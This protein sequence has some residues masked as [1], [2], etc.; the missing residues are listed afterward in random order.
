MRHLINKYLLISLSL[1][2]LH[3]QA[4]EQNFNSTQQQSVLIELFT[5]EGCSSC[6]PAE[7]YLNALKHHPQLWSVYIPVAF[8]VDYWDYLGWRDPY[9]YMAHAKRQYWY[10]KQR[11]LRTVY[12]PAFV[13]NGKA[14]RPGWINRELPKIASQ[15]GE[16]KVTVNGKQLTA[17][18]IPLRPLTEKLTL[19]IAVLAMN[20]VSHIQAGENTGRTA[21]HEFVV[22]G[23]KYLDSINGQWADNLPELHY[24]AAREH[25]I[26]VWISR[27]DDPTPLQAVGGQLS[28]FIE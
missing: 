1:M 26:A 17:S 28:Q 22:V 4:E 24:K 9:A 3:V 7:E 11:N 20:L 19:N 16:L 18:Y 23:Y 25:A 2:S 10:A 6:P 8:H 27:P 12:T 13:V 21:Q 14:W 15:S 5:S